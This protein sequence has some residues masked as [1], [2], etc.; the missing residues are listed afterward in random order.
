MEEYLPIVKNFGDPVFTLTAEVYYNLALAFQGDDEAFEKVVQMMTV[1]FDIGFRAFAVSMSYLVAEGYLNTGDPASGLNWIEKIL[2]HVENTGTHFSTAELKRLKGRALLALGKPD[3]SAEIEF[4]NA[5]KLADE[6]A[7]MTFKLRA[8]M[9]LSRLWGQQGKPREALDLVNESY[10]WFTE[11]FD[12]V[13]L[14]EAR[15]L[16]MELEKAQAR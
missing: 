13:D 5:L 6:Q 1:C 8:A 15:S 12:S 3:E 9:D 2:S 14:K 10:G 11:G 4:K 16:M 7:A